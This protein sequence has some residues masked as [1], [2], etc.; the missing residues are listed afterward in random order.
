VC[1]AGWQAWFGDPVPLALGM[2]TGPV[3]PSPGTW[4]E[5]F[6]CGLCQGSQNFWVILK[7]SQSHWAAHGPRASE[8]L[9]WKWQIL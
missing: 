1:L 5:R 7:G 4:C 8:W 6:H 3:S 9:V 2:S